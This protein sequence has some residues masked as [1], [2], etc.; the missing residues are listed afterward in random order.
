V[1]KNGDPQPTKILLNAYPQGTSRLAPVLPCSL[2][3]TEVWKNQEPPTS[4]LSLS[5]TKGEILSLQI[6]TWKPERM[7]GELPFQIFRYDIHITPLPFKVQ[8]PMSRTLS[9]RQNRALSGGKKAAID[10]ADT[11]TRKKE[12]L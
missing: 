12:T 3:A 8:W 6:H 9:P 4:L 11:T 5:G 2:A 7:L 10:L 1:L